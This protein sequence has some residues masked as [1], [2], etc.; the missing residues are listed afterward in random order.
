LSLF[1]R[2]LAAVG[3]FADVVVF[4]LRTVADRSHRPTHQL[5]WRCDVW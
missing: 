3:A 1:D 4:D 5:G 2:G